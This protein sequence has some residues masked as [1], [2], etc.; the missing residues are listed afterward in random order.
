MADMQKKKRIYTVIIVFLALLIAIGASLLAIANYNFRSCYKTDSVNIVANVET[1]GTLRVTDQRTVELSSGAQNLQ[2]PI[3]KT[4][5]KSFVQVSSIRIVKPAGD[6]GQTDAQVL[7]LNRNTLNAEEIERVHFNPQAKIS[8]DM[9][10]FFDRETNCIY[11]SAGDSLEYNAKYVLEVNYIIQDSV[12]IYDD[13][14]EVYWDWIPGYTNSVIGEAK[15]LIQMPVNTSVLP[16]LGENL[17]AWDHGTNGQIDYAGEA[18]FRVSTSN[19]TSGQGS[20]IHVLYT[21]YWMSNIERA[22]EMF[23]SGARRDMALKEEVKWG[24]GQNARIKNS[25]ILN[26]ALTSIIAILLIYTVVSYGLNIKRFGNLTRSGN[27]L[28]THL[29][30]EAFDEHIYRWQITMLVFSAISIVIMIIG[31]AVLRAYIG[32]FSCLLL[33][34]V[35]IALAS[36]SPF[37]HN[38]FRDK[39]NR[40]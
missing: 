36:S 2:I 15:L 25:Y 21:K 35:C 26:I 40:T 18:A 39:I 8:P 20:R 3:S 34:L 29:L 23:V 6:G 5:D 24:D 14:A 12:Y 38:S 27:Q 31:I 33:C 28:V 13:M 22:S 11:V 1:D 16:Q 9:T 30:Q 19:L 4:T 32:G 17:W 10:Y 7:T 37:I